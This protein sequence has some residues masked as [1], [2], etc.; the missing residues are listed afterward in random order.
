MATYRPRS[1][2][3]TVCS[4]CL[5]GRGRP[6]VDKNGQVMAGVHFQRMTAQRR[7][8]RAAINYYAGLNLRTRKV[9]PQ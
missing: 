7:E 8:V 9:A 5:A 3:Q 6:C 4:Q 2:S 1:N